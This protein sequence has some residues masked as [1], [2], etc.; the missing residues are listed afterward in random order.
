MT[1]QLQEPQ[2]KRWTREQYYELAKHG[3]LRGQRVQL[4]EGEIIEMAPQGLPHMKAI[5]AL[6]RWAVTHFDESYSVAS[7]MPLNALEHSDPEPDL[8]IIQG[9]IRSQTDHPSTAVLI[10]EVSDSSLHLDHRKADLY[11]AAKVDEYWIVDLISRKVEVYR[12]PVVD[13]QGRYGWKYAEVSTRG[14]L[15]SLVPLALPAAKL[16]IGDLF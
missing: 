10:V 11:A 13:P 5:M 8:A 15:E 1:L 6:T 3:W 4:I 16:M 9:S 2:T 7:Q 14:E 12:S